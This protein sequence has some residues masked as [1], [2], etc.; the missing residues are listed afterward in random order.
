MLYRDWLCSLAPGA[1]IY[2]REVCRRRYSEMTD[3]ITL[4]YQTAQQY[5]RA[6][7]LTALELA[8]EQQMYGAEYLRAILTQARATAPVSAAQRGSR[9]AHRSMSLGVERDLA[10]YEDYVANRA[11]LLAEPE[12]R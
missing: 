7:F 12:A 6:E 11:S 5:G 8:A 1:S 3:Q 9:V 4:L 10:E 2:V